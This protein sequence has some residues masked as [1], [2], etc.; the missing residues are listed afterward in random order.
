MIEILKIELLKIGYLSK[1]YL[2]GRVERPVVALARVAWLP[3]NF[4]EAIVETEV[5]ADRVLPAWVL[6]LVVAE[7]LL[8]ELADAAQR[9][10]A[11]R[12]MQNGHRDQGDIGQVRLGVVAIFVQLVV[13][14]AVVQA[15]RAAVRRLFRWFAGLLLVLVAVLVVRVYGER[16]FKARTIAVRLLRNGDHV[17]LFHFLFHLEHTGADWRSTSHF[18]DQFSNHFTDHLAN[19]FKEFSRT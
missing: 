4:D 17:D 18:A 3:W 1:L 16:R 9:R 7:A 8:D 10:P 14:L 6:L 5:V 12:R 11:I 15:G 2:R 13:V 19:H